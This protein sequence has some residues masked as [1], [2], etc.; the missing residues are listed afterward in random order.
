MSDESNVQY[1]QTPDGEFHAVDLNDPHAISHLLSLGVNIQQ[2]KE[3]G[4]IEDTIAE[5]G[6]VDVHHEIKD[7][8]EEVGGV[9]VHQSALPPPSPL[10]S[11]QSSPTNV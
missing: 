6:N 8:T 5:G 11:V 7:M 10:S 2:L 3:F 1:V 9:E 4:I